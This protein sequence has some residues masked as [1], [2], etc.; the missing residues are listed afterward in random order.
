VATD[1]A[2]DVTGTEPKDVEVQ[3]SARLKDGVVDLLEV[4]DVAV[5]P[6]NEVLHLHQVACQIE[7]RVVGDAVHDRPQEEACLGCV[8][9][10]SGQL[11]T[12][13]GDVLA[14]TDIPRGPPRERP[15]TYSILASQLKVRSPSSIRVPSVHMPLLVST[16][17]D[18]MS[19]TGS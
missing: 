3:T 8:E 4:N 18:G 7:C 19:C 2:Y 5:H 14:D 12:F 17:I 6:I 13:E 1:Q 16:E 11:D 9:N 10:G 15:A